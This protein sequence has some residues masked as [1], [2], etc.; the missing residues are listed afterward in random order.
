MKPVS[1]YEVKGSYRL[2]SRDKVT[3]YAHLA[4]S[5]DLRSTRWL[6]REAGHNEPSACRPYAAAELRESA[7]CPTLSRR[8]TP[9]FE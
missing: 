4:D 9:G 3:L 7:L 1:V 2:T 6:G 8:G 5:G